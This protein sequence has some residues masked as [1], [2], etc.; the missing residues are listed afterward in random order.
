[1]NHVGYSDQNSKHFHT[2][3]FYITAFLLSKGFQLV[4]ISRSDPKRSEFIL[5]DRPD[6]KELIQSFNFAPEDSL[7]VQI[8]SRKFV[9]AIKMLKDRL[10][11]E[12]E[13]L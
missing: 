3:N 8:D 5:G 4:D 6:R 13:L 11:Q 9:T 2:S 10:Y 7:E 1:M 12:K